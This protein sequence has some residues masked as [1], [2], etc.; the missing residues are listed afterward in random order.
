MNEEDSDKTAF[1]CREGQFKFKTMPFRLCNAGATFQQLMDMV[2]SGLAFEVCLVH[3]DDVIV[4]V[5]LSTIT[6]VG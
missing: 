4:L 6:S 3:L 5:P 2:M 1:I